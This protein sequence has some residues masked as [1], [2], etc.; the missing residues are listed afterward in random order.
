MSTYVKWR[1]SLI[2][3][4]SFFILF[5]F[6]YGVGWELYDI[7]ERE[8]AGVC[9]RLLIVSG[10]SLYIY[11]YRKKG[12][13]RKRERK[14]EKEWSVRTAC[15]RFASSLSC[16]GGATTREG[17][18]KFKTKRERAGGRHHD[19]SHIHH[20]RLRMIGQKAGTWLRKKERQK[21]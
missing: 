3:I 17:R 19:R 10:E 14:K 6:F 2:S 11:T 1:A 15:V 16:V 4:T 8:T 9:S 12:T 13:L 18:L 5:F 7:R 21:R 20:D